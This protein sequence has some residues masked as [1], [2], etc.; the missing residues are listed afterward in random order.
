[1]RLAS[2]IA[3][4]SACVLWPSP[5]PPASAWRTGATKDSASSALARMHSD[6]VGSRAIASKSGCTKR[7]WLGHICVGG[8]KVRK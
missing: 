6:C 4:S 3:S 1:V 5:L 7:H 8:G 2:A